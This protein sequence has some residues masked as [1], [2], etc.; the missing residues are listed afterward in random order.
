[1]YIGALDIGGTKTIVAVVDE[2]GNIYKKE[3]F[4]TNTSDIYAHLDYCACVLRN[5]LKQLNIDERAL[6]GIGVTL[7]GIV[8][9]E[10][11]ILINAPYEKW[12]NV[13]V[14]AYLSDMFHSIS[15]FC[16][17]DVNA[18]AIGEQF[19]GIG[20]KYENY[21]WM[22][23]ST[24]VGGAVVN[25]S[26]LVKG[27]NGFAGE[28][29]HLKVEYDDPDICPCGQAGC[30]EAHGSGTAI[31]KAIEKRV[32][33][34]PSFGE[35]FNTALQKQDASGCAYLAKSGNKIAV[36]IFEQTGEYLGKGISYCV[37][38]LNPQAVII[39]GGVAAS[40]DLLLP[41][42]RSA[43]EKYTFKPMQDIEIV[44]TPLGYEAA[45][46]GAASLVL[47]GKEQIHGN[48]GAK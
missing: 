31:S 47:Q 13:Q 14:S 4:S 23:V 38:I 41:G 11:G 27:M 25:D 32:R 22:T 39:G 15:I 43:I 18:C 30:L 24:G 19:F 6:S 9:S 34:E 37:N 1:M 44:A 46:L 16:E 40:L 28:F 2:K 7:P 17:N 35:A 8:N 5:L 21:I 26:K 20:K 33:K 36:Q 10:K 29:G 45:L 42:I 3:K 12:E 48:E